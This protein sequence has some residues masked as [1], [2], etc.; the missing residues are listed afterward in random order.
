MTIACVNE[1]D[2]F[3]LEAGEGLPCLVMHGG[4][5][6]DH[7]YLGPWLD[8]LG[9]EMRLIYYDHRGNGRSG[10]PPVETL[11]FDHFCADADALREH[12]GFEK[13][14][15][16]GHS[17]GGWIALEYALRYP[18]RLS[19][20]ILY[21]TAPAFDYRAEIVDN[22]RRKGATAEQVAAFSGPIPD[23]AV[24]RRCMEIL[25]P[26]Y[27]HSFDPELAGRA[28]GETLFNVEALRRSMSLISEWNVVSRLGEVRVPTLILV[29]D[30]DFCTPVSQSQRLHEGITGSEMVVFERSGH[31][32]HL[33][34]PD[35]FF[36]AVREWLVSKSPAPEATPV[37]A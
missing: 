4:L 22:M 2:L 28:M 5:G 37:V 14:A 18:E 11:T 20:L 3:Y 9:E 36:D 19:H 34:S 33:E 6:L 7:T 24:F 30:D 23:D 35:I 17:Y 15:V 1:I 16:L 31:L 29:D 10:R 13:V 26:L 21:G 27:W 32:P 12:L 8:P 25:G